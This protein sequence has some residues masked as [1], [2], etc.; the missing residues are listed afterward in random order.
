M[1][2]EIRFLH[3]YFSAEFYEDISVES[4]LKILFDIKEK[5]TLQELDA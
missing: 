4:R 3:P 1:K 2:S 5:W